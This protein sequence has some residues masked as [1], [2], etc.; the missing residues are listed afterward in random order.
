MNRRLLLEIGTRSDATRK[1]LR[2]FIFTN[3]E[4]IVQSLKS[5]RFHKYTL[6]DIVKFPAINK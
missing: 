3:K 6:D 4:K 5:Q 1:K 2:T